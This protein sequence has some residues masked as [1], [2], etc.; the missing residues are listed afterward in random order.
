MIVTCSICN[1]CRYITMSRYMSVYVGMCMVLIQKYVQILPDTY[2]YIQYLHIQIYL[3]IP[4]YT[5]NTYAYMQYIQIQTYLDIL[6]I[7]TDTSDTYIYRY[8]Y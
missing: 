7:P 8:T 1:Y 6:M 5:S 3:H 4:S 2:I